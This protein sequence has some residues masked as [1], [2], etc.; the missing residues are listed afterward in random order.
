LEDLRLDGKII[1]K[2]ILKEW[3]E[4]ALTGLMWLRI[5]TTDG[6]LRTW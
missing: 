3:N 1:L 4:R 2:F 6:V 5:G